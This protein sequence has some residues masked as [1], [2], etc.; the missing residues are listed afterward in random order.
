MSISGPGYKTKASQSIFSEVSANGVIFNRAGNVSNAYLS[1]GT[2]PC[3]DTGF[4][5]KQTNAEI[6]YTAVQVSGIY[7]FDVTIYEWN[8]TTETTLLTISVT[9]S[10]SGD[11]TPITPIDIT[12]NN[13]LRAKITSGSCKDPIVQVF[14]SG[15]LQT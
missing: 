3:N 10:N 6:T 8:G 5:V 7:T 2:V 15:E 12:Q 9:S 14:F 13:E 11:Y 4:P 1:I